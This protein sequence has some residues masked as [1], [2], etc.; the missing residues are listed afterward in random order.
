M[1]QTTKRK[2]AKEIIIFFISAVI[3]GLIWTIFWGI[4]QFNTHKSASLQ[5]QIT[6]L[7]HETDSIQASYSKVKTFSDLITGK[8]PIEYLNAD[9]TWEEVLP[10]GQDKFTPK[11]QRACNIRELYK[12]LTTSK[13]KF[14]DDNFIP[15]FPSFQK[16]IEKELE[17][18]PSSALRDSLKKNVNVMATDSILLQPSLSKIYN[19]L[20]K[21]RFLSVDYNEF[22]STV[23]FYELL[24]DIGPLDEI[25]KQKDKLENDLISSNDKVYSSNELNEIGKS[26]CIISL[27]IIYPFRFLFLMLVWAV[28]TLRQKPN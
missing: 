6:N 20:K 10:I 4:N 13:F 14:S 23:D 9:P 21:E 2:I 16:D 15:D 25:L 3:V 26:L 27:I 17:I 22:I 5:A 28:R 12:L 11:E 19:F 18:E 7:E 1:K 24:P 8:V